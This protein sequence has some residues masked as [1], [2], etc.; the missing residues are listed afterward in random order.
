ME[1]I[2][3]KCRNDALVGVEVGIDPIFLP[4]RHQNTTLKGRVQNR[5][6]SISNTHELTSEN[7]KQHTPDQCRKEH[8]EQLINFLLHEIHRQIHCSEI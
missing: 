3:V 6:A 1:I 2:E 4:S 5:K 7:L 8:L